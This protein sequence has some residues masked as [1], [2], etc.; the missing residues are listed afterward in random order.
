MPRGDFSGM[1]G[2]GGGQEQTVFHV[3]CSIFHFS[4]NRRKD[5]QTI[6]ELRNISNSQNQSGVWAMLQRN[7]SN[8]KGYKSINFFN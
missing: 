5:E 7:G 2:A 3:P 1:G 6:C 8:N 4:F